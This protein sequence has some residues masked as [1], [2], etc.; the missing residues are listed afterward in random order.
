M[1]ADFQLS[2]YLEEYDI[3]KVLLI[4]SDTFFMSDDFRL[5]G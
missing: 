1:G 4:G 5:E 2:A 3:H